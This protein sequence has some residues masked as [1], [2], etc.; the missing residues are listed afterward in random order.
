M[1]RTF[2][3]VVLRPEVVDS[4]DHIYSHDVVKSACYDYLKSCRNASVLEH[5]I[6]AESNAVSVVEF[7][8]APTDYEVNGTDVLKGDWVM[9]AQIHDDTIWEACQNGTFKA[10]SVGCRGTFETMEVVDD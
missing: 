6:E 10:F 1:D 4:H 8:I 7:F 5:Y 3:S 9:T 2:T